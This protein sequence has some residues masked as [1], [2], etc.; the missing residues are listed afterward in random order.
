M[1][2]PLQIDELGGEP[3]EHLVEAVEVH[4]DDQA[5][6]DDDERRLPGLLPVREID[7][8]ELAADLAAEREESADAA[9]HPAL[10]LDVAARLALGLAGDGRGDRATTGLPVSAGRAGHLLARLL[11][12]R[13]PPAEAAVLRELDPV[14]RVPLRLLRLVVAPLAV[15]ARKRNQHADTGLRHWGRLLGSWAPG[16]APIRQDTR[17]P[18]RATPSAGAADARLD[19]RPNP[20]RRPP[21]PRGAALRTDAPAFARALPASAPVALR[22][23][24]D[25]LDDRVGGRLPGVRR[26]GV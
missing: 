9:A 7:L 1:R 15:L 3:G 8:G 22:R 4:P 21:G 24:P 25:A 5:R 23:R 18:H 20:P 6:R 19:R 2:L 13:V 16:P 12:G 10:A 14:G 11:M 26:G 17:D